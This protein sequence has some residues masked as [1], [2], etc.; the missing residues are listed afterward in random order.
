MAFTV[1]IVVPVPSDIRPALGYAARVFAGSDETLPMS[2]AVVGTLG[3]Q[4][5]EGL[6]VEGL[7]SSVSGY[8]ATM[9]EVG[10]ELSLGV[11]DPEPVATGL[12][13]EGEGDG[14]IA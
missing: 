2:A 1:L 14:P 4:S 6:Q 7:G 13:F 8:L 12:T 5:I 9:P 3:G 11:N 10:D